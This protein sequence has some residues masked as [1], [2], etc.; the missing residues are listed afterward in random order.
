MLGKDSQGVPGMLGIL[1]TAKA[2]AEVSKSKGK[3]KRNLVVNLFTV[4]S[5]A[6][7][8]WCVQMGKKKIIHD[9]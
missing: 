8:L 2:G 6:Q 9:L 7:N 4:T 1:T 5:L 3:S